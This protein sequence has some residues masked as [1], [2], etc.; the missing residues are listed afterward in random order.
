MSSTPK[1]NLARP[2]PMDVKN[3]GKGLERLGHCFVRSSW[4][5]YIKML[6]FSSKNGL[7]RRF[8]GKGQ[9]GPD[10]EIF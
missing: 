7:I 2:P 1:T 8:G 5:F 10:R 3:E 9:R 4:A 6:H